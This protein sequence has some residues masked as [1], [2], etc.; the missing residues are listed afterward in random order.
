MAT[1]IKIKRSSIRKNPNAGNEVTLIPMGW[2]VKFTT[3]LSFN[4]LPEWIQDSIFNHTFNSMEITSL[5]STTGIINGVLANPN[6]INKMIEFAKS[7][8]GE[9]YFT[10]NANRE[11]NTFYHRPEPEYFYSYENPKV[12]CANC[13]KLVNVNDIEEDEMED[14]MV[15]ICP[16]CGYLDYY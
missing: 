10:I 7:V 14:N 5:T 9:N 12:K 6:K 3:N 8:K 15:Q 11:I 13:H 4:K 2:D 16:K 1:L